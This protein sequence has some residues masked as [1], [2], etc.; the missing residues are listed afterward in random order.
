MQWNQIIP[1]ISFL[2]VV[3]GQDLDWDK[4]GRTL[5]DHDITS[6]STLNAAVQAEFPHMCTLFRKVNGF[7]T[8]IGGASL[9]AAN[10]LLTLA[11]AVHLMRNFTLEESFKAEQ[12][13]NAEICDDS[14]DV[15]MEIFVS[16]GDIHLQSNNNKEKQVRQVSAI[17]IHPDYNPKSLINDLAVLIVEEP[18]IFSSSVGRVCLPSPHTAVKT[19]AVLVATGHGRDFFESGSYS[20]ELRKVNLPMWKSSECEKVL[21][22]EHFLNTTV[23]QW[24]IHP[25]FLCA[26]GKVDSDTCEGDGGGPLVTNSRNLQPKGQEEETKEADP[27]FGND[28]IFNDEVDLRDSNNE[29]TKIV[30]VGVIAWG[31]KCGM[32]GLPSVYSSV[33]SGRCWLDQVM[34]C[35]PHDRAVVDITAGNLDLRTT[36]DEPDS[37]GGLTDGDCVAWLESEGSSR[38]ACGCKQILREGTQPLETLETGEFDL[39]ITE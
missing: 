26:G 5:A 34:S 14:H 29:A 20:R 1:L 38:A 7:N 10:Q 31:I 16:C 36:D 39:R 30:Q 25:S 8:F 32:D 12:A 24:T 3:L 18:F 23:R 6:V 27:I 21:N 2:S 28:D 19:D 9:I 17:L 35:Y 15:N 33:V 11:T 4:C 22:D 13:N 37:V